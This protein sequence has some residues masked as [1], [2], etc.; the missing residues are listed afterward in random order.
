MD[1]SDGCRIRRHLFA[2]NGENMLRIEVST[3]K[4]DVKD[5]EKPRRSMPLQALGYAGFLTT[6]FCAKTPSSFVIECGWGGRE[7]DP[8]AAV[9]TKG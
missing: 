7:I 3:T 1:A 6:S 5:C 9:R 2:L 4:F 8:P